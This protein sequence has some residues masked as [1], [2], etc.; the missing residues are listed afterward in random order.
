MGLDLWN[1]K[2]PGLRTSLLPNA[3]NGPRSH[4]R[5]AQATNSLYGTLGQGYN[6]LAGFPLDYANGGVDAGFTYNPIFSF[7]PANPTTTG[8]WGSTAACAETFT[9]IPY[10]TGQQLLDYSASL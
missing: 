9:Y 5:L 2:G 10:Y 8:E 7:D 6:T 1:G 3:T 4:R